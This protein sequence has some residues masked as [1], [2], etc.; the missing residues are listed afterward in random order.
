M[1]GILY[2]VTTG[3][4]WQD[5]SYKYRPKSTFHRFNLYLHENEIY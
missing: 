1:N 3:C 4:T 2:I 5:V